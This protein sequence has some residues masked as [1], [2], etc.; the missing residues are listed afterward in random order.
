VTSEDVEEELA[1]LLRVS[2]AGWPDSGSPG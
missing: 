1:H 2:D